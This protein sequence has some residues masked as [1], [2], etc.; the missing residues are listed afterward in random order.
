M[1]R[2]TILLSLSLLLSGCGALSLLEGE[3]NR[4]VFELRAP[5]VTAGQC[6]G[7]RVSELVI[8][9]PKARGTLDSERIMIR[10]SALETRYLPD[11]VWGDPV[12]VMVQRLLVE[13]LGSY[14][15]FGHVGREP[16]GL[17]GDYA[18]ISEISSFNAELQNEG[19][20]IRLTVDAQLVRE[21]D[22]SV[23]SRGSF[24][25]T[26]VA[27]STRTADL[28]PAFDAAAQDLIGE[29]SAWSLRR[30]GANPANC[31]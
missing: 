16:L 13:T 26:S 14:D 24:E 21:L 17:S 7:Q 20:L 11:A 12:P 10:P 2:S 22:A 1:F 18:M 5:E 6:G 29:M 3:P 27:A 9:L 4:D 15:S 23:V 8:E 28:I 19:A 30:L 25:A 31:S